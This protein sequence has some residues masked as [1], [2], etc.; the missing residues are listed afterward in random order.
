MYIF[1]CNF[2]ALLKLSLNIRL[3]GSCWHTLG[4]SESGKLSQSN[5][6][7][8]LVSYRQEENTAKKEIKNKIKRHSLEETFFNF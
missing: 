5:T 3:K 1:T 4:F 7:V 8:M 6:A 2:K